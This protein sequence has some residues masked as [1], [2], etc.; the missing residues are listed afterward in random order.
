MKDGKD[1]YYSTNGG[2]AD[3]QPESV[4]LLLETA[5]L[6]T[7]IDKER[8]EEALKRAERKL[9]DNDV[10]LKRAKSAISRARNRLK[11]I[12]R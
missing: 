5:E 3:I 12:S 1:Y 9:K 2:Y 11:I 6:I 8:A 10:N 7:D 4:L